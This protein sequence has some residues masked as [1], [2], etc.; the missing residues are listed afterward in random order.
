MEENKTE[1]KVRGLPF[2]VQPPYTLCF[3]QPLKEFVKIDITT[4]LPGHFFPFGF[5]LHRLSSGLNT[6]KFKWCGLK[7]VK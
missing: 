3:I 4:L 5:I 6:G 1:K 7:R 2:F